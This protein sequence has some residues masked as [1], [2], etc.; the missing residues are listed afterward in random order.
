MLAADQNNLDVGRELTL[1]VLRE[2]HA[3]ESTA[4]YNYALFAHDWGLL[5]PAAAKRPIQQNQGRQL[6]SSG[7]RQAQFGAKQIA[8]SIQGIEQ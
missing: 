6:F 1:K 3:S 5:L 8:V 2:R 7:L 4:D